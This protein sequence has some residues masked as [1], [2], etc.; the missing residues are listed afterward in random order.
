L[1]RRRARR[2]GF[3][4]ILIVVVAAGNA[5]DFWGGHSWGPEQAGTQAIWVHASA[6]LF[7]LALG[8]LFLCLRD[9]GSIVLHGSHPPTIDELDD[10]THWWSKL[11]AN[12]TRRFV[13]THQGLIGFVGLSA[14]ALFGHFLWKP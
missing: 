10:T 14:G 6:A 1:R 11:V 9:L 8:M 3:I 7:W 4:W 12:P 2:V 13:R 5:W